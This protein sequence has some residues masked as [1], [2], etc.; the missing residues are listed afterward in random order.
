[1]DII[2]VQVWSSKVVDNALVQA[3]LVFRWGGVF[4]DNPPTTRTTGRFA[5]YGKVHPEIKSLR[6]LPIPRVNETKQ[7]NETSV[8][9]TV[10]WSR[11]LNAVMGSQLVQV[12]HI[13]SFL[14]SCNPRSTS[15]KRG[16]YCR[17]FLHIHTNVHMRIWLVSWIENRRRGPIEM[18][19]KSNWLS[20]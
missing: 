2:G 13:S 8:I 5:T 20:T 7:T 10:A 18:D 9:S 4:D 6:L 1:M 12:Y 3:C 16:P 19:Q 11:T 17:T 15:V 14:W